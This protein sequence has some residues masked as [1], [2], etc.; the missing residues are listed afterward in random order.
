MGGDKESGSPTQ[1][2]E[3]TLSNEGRIVVF[4]GGGAFMSFAT[5]AG[6]KPMILFFAGATWLAATAVEFF[7]Q[8]EERN[9]RK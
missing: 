8:Q 5:L 4:T 3:P 7:I 9:E 2:H 6:D 1:E